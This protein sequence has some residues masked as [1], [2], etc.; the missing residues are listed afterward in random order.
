MHEARCS[1]HGSSGCFSFRGMDRFRANLVVAGSTA[2][3][4]DHWK[5]IRIGSVDFLVVKPCARCQVTTIDQA[6]GETSKEPLKT[7]ATYRKQDGKVM[8]GMNLVAHKI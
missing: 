8:F 1:Y 4:E 5:Q 7:L 3:A 6:T 2:F